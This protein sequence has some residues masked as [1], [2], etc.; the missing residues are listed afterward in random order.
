MSVHKTLEKDYY[1]GGEVSVCQKFLL[2]GRGL[3]ALVFSRA[4]KHLNKPNCGLLVQVIKKEKQD[5]CC[6]SIFRQ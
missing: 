3:C 2:S 6:F 1:V 4:N 5:S